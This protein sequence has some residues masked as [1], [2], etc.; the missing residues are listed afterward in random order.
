MVQMPTK[1][2]ERSDAPD[3]LVLDPLVGRKVQSSSTRSAGMS[4]PQ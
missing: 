1:R 2:F 3:R 4:T